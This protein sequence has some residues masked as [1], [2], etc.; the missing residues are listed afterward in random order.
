VARHP[1]RAPASAAR[2]V[3]RPVAVMSFVPPRELRSSWSRTTQHF[4]QFFFP[5][6]NSHPRS[7]SEP[8]RLLYYHYTIFA[9][10]RWNRDTKK[11]RRKRNNPSP[12][13]FSSSHSWRRWRLPYPLFFASIRLI[14]RETNTNLY[15]EA[16]FCELPAYDF[17]EGWRDDNHPQKR[18]EKSICVA[19]LI[20]FFFFTSQV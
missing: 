19:D 14:C 1:R 5:A 7:P 10:Y 16:L 2:T 3:I 13:L 6:S 8:N 4:R 15:H 11:S 20:Y 17:D 12:F 9:C 18:P